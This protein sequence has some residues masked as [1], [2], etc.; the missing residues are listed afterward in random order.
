[1]SAPAQLAA[2]GSSAPL[3]AAIYPKGVNFSVFARDATR[4]ELVL[5]DGEAATRPAQTVPL[6]SSS[7]R[8]GHY[9]HAFVPGLR[10]SVV[11]L[12]HRL[13]GAWRA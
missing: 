8:S 7:H 3:G 4:V 1:M 12:A 6:D 9:W 10:P 5:F 11:L 2:P 13:D